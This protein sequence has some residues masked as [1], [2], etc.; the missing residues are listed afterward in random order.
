MEFL[1]IMMIIRIEPSNAM[2]LFGFQNYHK[3]II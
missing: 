1:S 3:K 2:I